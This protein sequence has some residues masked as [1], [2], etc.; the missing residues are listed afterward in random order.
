MQTGFYKDGVKIG[1]WWTSPEFVPKLLLQG[2]LTVLQ[3]EYLLR[4]GVAQVDDHVLRFS[5][6]DS[7]NV[8]AGKI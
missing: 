6:G 5:K 4:D 1:T 8:P 7:F 2:C 3:A